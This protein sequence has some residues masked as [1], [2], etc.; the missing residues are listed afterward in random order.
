MEGSIAFAALERTRIEI[1]PN[2]RVRGNGTWARL[3]DVS[4]PIAVND[5]VTVYESEGGV[6]GEGVVT[7]IDVP[8][9]RVYLSVDWPSL[10]P[11][12]AL[13]ADPLNQGAG[14]LLAAVGITMLV[15]FVDKQRFLLPQ[16]PVTTSVSVVTNPEL[17]LAAS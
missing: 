14:S 9:E 12:A 17:A 8:A 2:F 10:R 1:D 5:P 15:N 16:P 11:A 6:I 13:V 3:K 4:G 7:D